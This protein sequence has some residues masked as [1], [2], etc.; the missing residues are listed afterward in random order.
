MIL[1]NNINIIPKLFV[2]MA[3]LILSDESFIQASS[4]THTITTNFKLKD[5]SGRE[6]ALK[7]FRG[8]I[9]LLIFG[10]LYQENTLKAFQDVKKIMKEKKSFRDS[11]EVLLIISERKKPEEY[12]TVKEG[13]EINCPVLLDNDRNVYAQY[14]IIAI[15]TTFIIDRNGK[16]LTKLASYTISYYDQ[17]YAE[18][19]Y[20]T[21][22]V[23]D[24][25]LESVMNPKAD[26]PYLNGKNERFL[27][28]ADN[29]KKRGFYESALNSYKEIIENNPDLKEAHIGIG[30]IYLIK[31]ETDKAEKEFN[32][33]LE[34]H[35]DDPA[36]LKGIAQVFFL[37]GN[38]DKAE[39]FLKKVMATDYIDEDLYY[40]MGEV[41]EK[42]GD[43]EKA[44]EYYKKNCTQLLHFGQNKIIVQ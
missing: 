4:L 41:Y 34:K 43:L 6:L 31:K 15:P 20:L 18:L 38:T 33:V 36:A 16:I 21:G 10:E 26:A 23:D 17:L 27:S 13:L 9:V 7:D 5:L 42:K 29:L 37:R 11:I 39:Y 30:N 1:K 28:F 35:P 14:E 3:L 19:G 12:I 40:I 2:L 24:A 44:I 22:E 25:E 32:T 8:K